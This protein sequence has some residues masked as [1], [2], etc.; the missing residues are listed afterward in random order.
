MADKK[1]P[2]EEGG[3]EDNRLDSAP[4]ETRRF[5]DSRRRLPLAALAVLLALIG[6]GVYVAWPDIQDS[7]RPSPSPAVAEAESVPVAEP[8]A[9]AEPEPEIEPIPAVEA[10]PAPAIEESPATPPEPS[11][12][13]LAL[14]EQVAALQR[15]LAER[16]AAPPPAPPPAPDLTPIHDAMA[17]LEELEKRLNEVPP[18]QAASDEAT[19]ASDEASAVAAPAMDLQARQRLNAVERTLALAEF[20]RRG[21]EFDALR[22]AQAK[23]RD[24]VAALSQS[25]AAV[26]GR[27]A[28][29]ERVMVLVLALSRLSRATATAPP[30]G[31]EME[32]FSAAAQA[33]G[34]TGLAFDNAMREL[35]A[36]ALAGAP[37]L[38][39]LT[40]AYDDVALAVIQADADAEDQGWVDATIGR[41]RRIVTLRRVGGDIAA[42]SLEG[43]LSA[44]HRALAGGDLGAAIALAEALPAKARSG[45]EDWLR[46]ARARLAVERALAVLD[47]EISARVAARWAPRESPDK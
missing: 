13:L 4:D 15:A 9:V 3:T 43:R 45:A 12:A 29:G 38:A 7:L 19:P 1:E 10:E 23:L 47:G 44:L 34:A 35:A 30:F 5:G 41:L 32:A 16:D 22:A 6:I 46:G 42:D 33:G 18:P 25:L 2:P 17:R 37:T 14:A 36:H 21:G 27:E 8:P 26:G 31:R 39:R 20:D 24:R 28:E 40:A 11:P